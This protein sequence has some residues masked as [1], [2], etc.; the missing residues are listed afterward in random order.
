MVAEIQ[1][2]L[3]VYYSGWHHLVQAQECHRIVWILPIEVQAHNMEREQLEEMSSHALLSLLVLI[4]EI[5]RSRGAFEFP[6]VLNGPSCS[7]YSRPDV[8]PPPPMPQDQQFP[9]QSRRG[10]RTRFVPPRCSRHC[11]CGL[12]CDRI[13]EGHRHNRCEEH[14]RT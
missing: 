4:S 9:R 13:P 2:A 1:V 6:G 12:D 8:G 11:W 5:F 14:R 10:T 7:T 3:I